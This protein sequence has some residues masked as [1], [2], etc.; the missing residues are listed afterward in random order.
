MEIGSTR[1]SPAPSLPAPARADMTASV[2]AVPTELPPEASVQQVP[3]TEVARFEPS[4]GFAERAAI[5]AVVRAMVRQTFDIDPRT[6][7]V[8]AQ[9]VDSRT[10]EV[11]KQSPGEALL[12]MRA[13]LRAADEGQVDATRVKTIT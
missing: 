2:K 1:P 6:K 13:Y 8:V 5:D 9:V 10:G 4:E 11:V 12:R 3:P 7:D